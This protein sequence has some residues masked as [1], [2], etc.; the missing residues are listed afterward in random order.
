MIELDTL[1]EQDKGREV[2]YRSSFGDKTERGVI[3]SWNAHYIFVR[4]ERY[5]YVL[6]GEEPRL[7]ETGA[8]TSPEDLTFASD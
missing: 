1:T 2:I 8:A 3:S 6:R 5:G 4:Y 7:Q